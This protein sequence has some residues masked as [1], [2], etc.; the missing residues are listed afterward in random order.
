MKS[1]KA[2]FFSSHLGQNIGGAEL[3]SLAIIKKLQKKSKVELISFYPDYK[4]CNSQPLIKNVFYI[5][6]LHIL[7]RGL[8]FLNYLLNHNF[9]LNFFSARKADILIS[10]GIYS[11]SVVLRSR[12]KHKI[13]FVR[14][15][16]ELGIDKNYHKSLLRKI[17]KKFLI[18]IDWP[19]RRIYRYHLIK[20]YKKSIVVA[21][22]FYVKE[23]IY[24]NFGI[25]VKVEEPIIDIS[26]IKLL[27]RK[28]RSDIVFIGDSHWKGLHLVYQMA[29]ILNNLNFVVYSRFNLKGN[30]PKNILIK[31]WTTNKSEIFA[32]ANLVI[33]PSQAL[34]TYG[35]VSR[36]AFLLK[37]PVLVSNLG[38]LPETVDFKKEMIVE[39]YSSVSAWVKQILKVIN[40]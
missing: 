32:S 28:L 15:V 23:L 24:Q 37:I 19:F 7:R 1:K 22:S 5:N 18:F 8:P 20:A 38:G 10:Q 12:V 35:R 33:V 6:G 17:I 11:P 27:P 30:H 4:Y 40:K 34:E 31:N 3:S 36:E 9:L 2:I 14:S 25:S 16:L 26:E 29:S 21:N 13:I 39:D